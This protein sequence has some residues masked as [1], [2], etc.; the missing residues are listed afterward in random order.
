MNYL[1]IQE[2]RFQTGISTSRDRLSILQP[3]L[4]DT[5]ATSSLTAFL[6][7]YSH[8]NKML[9]TNTIYAY[10]VTMFFLNRFF[11]LK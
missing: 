10:I 4:S 7:L 3:C 5:A 8:V 1:Y 6:C 2:I 9:K 11:L